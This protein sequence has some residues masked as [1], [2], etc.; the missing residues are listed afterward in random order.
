M[1][2]AHRLATSPGHINIGRL[3]LVLDDAVI[4]AAFGGCPVLLQA[5]QI[6]ACLRVVGHDSRPRI[7]SRTAGVSGGAFASDLG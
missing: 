5:H 4:L 3:G 1:D 6:G 7:R 2:L